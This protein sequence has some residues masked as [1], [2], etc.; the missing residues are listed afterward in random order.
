MAVHIIIDGY[1]LIKQ[2]P[3]LSRFDY[4]DI[5]KSRNE[6]I[7][8]LVAYKKVKKHR[9]TV[10]FD[11]V[12]GGSIKQ[13]RTR[14][15]GID[16]IFSK[17]GEEA[18][19]VIK[20]AVKVGR[21]RLV[22]VTSDRQIVDFSEKRGAAVIPSG[23]FEMKMEMA[24]FAEEKGYDGLDDEPVNEAIQTKKKGPSKKLSKTQRRANVKIKK[25]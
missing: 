6:L 25:L 15:R 12:K 9:I 17:K 20:R 11:G 13:E 18:D 19:E 2:S 22:V 10:V 16:V 23:D 14:D 5:E 8:R 4:M 3:V 21:E 24:T 7:S 1:N